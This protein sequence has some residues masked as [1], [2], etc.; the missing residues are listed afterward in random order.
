MTISIYVEKIFNKIQHPF[1]I[2][3]QVNFFFNDYLFIY[4]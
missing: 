1:T 4:F 3:A 2:K